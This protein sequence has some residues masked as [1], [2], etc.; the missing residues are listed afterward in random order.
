MM[1]DF[2]WDIATSNLVL[3]IIAV[4][5]VAAFLVAHAPTLILKLWP[6][7]YLYSKAAALV[8]VAAA[9]LLCFL[10]G[11]RVSDERA[12]AKS[13]RA[14]IAA[15]QVDLNAAND[16][17]RKADAA[18][19]ELAEQAKADQERIEDYEERLRRRTPNT[20]CLLVPD[21]FPERLPNDR[22][23]AR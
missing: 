4:V 5:F 11:F 8:Q 19:A 18:R 23:R 21:D 6:T 22:K 15:Q 16:A 14:Q 13:L 20:A 17:A 2:V 12:E 9:A 1:M 10:I 3:G 7:A